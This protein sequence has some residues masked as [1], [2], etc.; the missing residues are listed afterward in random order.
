MAVLLVVGLATG[1]IVMAHPFGRQRLAAASSVP[2]SRPANASLSA[3]SPSAGPSTSPPPPPG[4]SPSGTSP[5]TR[6]QAA[7]NL[8]ALLAQSAGDR[9]G[10]NAAYNDVSQCG[11]TLTQD[12]LTLQTAA[13]SHRQLLSEL[14]QMP[15]ASALPQGMLRDLSG[16]WQASAS[17]DADFTK[18][19]QDEVENGCSPA[20]Q[21]D[22]NYAAADGPDIQATTSKTAF[23]QLWNPLAQAYG[24]QT[25]AQSDL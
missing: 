13:A 5:F 9:Q 25:Y 20:S 16:A 24:L 6:Q 3:E 23:V 11:P 4:S 2:A 18:W 22:P 7:V 21:S 19:A 14:A 15:G 1:V 12:V 8:A 10:V 17:A